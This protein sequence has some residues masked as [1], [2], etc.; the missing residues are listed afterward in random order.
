M[1]S[2]QIPR[3]CKPGNKPVSVSDSDSIKHNL[4]QFFAHKG[5]AVTA[6]C[7][8]IS[9]RSSFSINSNH[10]PNPDLT[11]FLTE[12]RCRLD[13]RL[14]LQTAAAH[15]NLCANPAKGE[16]LSVITQRCSCRFSQYR[17]STGAKFPHSC[18]ISLIY[19]IA[20]NRYSA[21]ALKVLVWHHVAL[22]LMN[23]YK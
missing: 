9:I 8:T 2:S 10:A 18:S 21:Q 3:T 20:A 13:V 15:S 11:C 4:S 19:S 1:T 6:Q 14:H 7:C 23:R 17:D 12:K 5:F 16:T 22:T